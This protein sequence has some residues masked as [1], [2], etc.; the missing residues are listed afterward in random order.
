MECSAYITT[1]SLKIDVWLLAYRP[2]VIYLPKIKCRY[3]NI[4]FLYWHRILWVLAYQKMEMYRQ[5]GVTLPTF[6]SGVRENS[7][8]IIFVG[9]VEKEAVFFY[10]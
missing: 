3:A 8:H 4:L 7:F 5:C 2:K 10:W 6:P 9:D 1:L